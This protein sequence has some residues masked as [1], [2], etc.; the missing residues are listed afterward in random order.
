MSYKPECQESELLCARY[1][2]RTQ[3]TDGE[4][5]VSIPALLNVKDNGRRQI[6]N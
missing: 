1:H 6:I 5:T 3:V 4:E 2:T